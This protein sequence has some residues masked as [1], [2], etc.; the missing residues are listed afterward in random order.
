[1][2]GSV[3]SSLVLS[4]RPVLSG[5]SREYPLAEVGEKS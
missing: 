4:L 2:K 5:L 1:M 3:Q